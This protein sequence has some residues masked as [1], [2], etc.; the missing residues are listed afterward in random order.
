MS[1]DR[2]AI[3]GHRAT[4]ATAA[5]AAAGAGSRNA[6]GAV[7]KRRE[8]HRAERRPVTDSAVCSIAEFAVPARQSGGAFVSSGWLLRGWLTRV[9]LAALA[10]LACLDSVVYRQQSACR[11][12]RAR[13][14]VHGQE[15]ERPVS[16]IWVQRRVVP[17][18]G[19]LT[20]RVQSG[21]ILSPA[22]SSRLH[23]A[24]WMKGHA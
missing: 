9:A 15:C 23:C 8:T 10:A 21:Q 24:F 4:A 20:C 17:T 16:E 6:H 19:W 1:P 5:A 3:S 18:T 12:E 22:P 13:R 2:P 7:T 11:T 14:T